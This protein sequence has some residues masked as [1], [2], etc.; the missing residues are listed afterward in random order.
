MLF[1]VQHFYGFGAREIVAGSI[2]KFVLV[3][4][5]S[6]EWNKQRRIH[7]RNCQEYRLRK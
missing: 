7:S 3:K 2:F 6:V 5:V 1:N 4:F